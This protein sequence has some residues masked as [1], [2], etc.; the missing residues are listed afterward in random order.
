MDFRIDPR[1][2][3]D[4]IDNVF[5][6]HIREKK[7]LEEKRYQEI[8][9]KQLE[10][11]EKY[12]FKSVDEIKQHLLSG[13]ILYPDNTFGKITINDEE[14]ESCYFEGDVEIEENEIGI[15]MF[16]C[17][18]MNGDRICFPFYEFERQFFFTLI[19][20]STGYIDKWH[21]GN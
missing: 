11:L 3:K 4:N 1:S 15:Q 19:P 14:I 8:K 21:K 10:H 9:K 2:N 6:K 17:V 7:E 13:K 16:V 5:H 20:G 18:C 12:H